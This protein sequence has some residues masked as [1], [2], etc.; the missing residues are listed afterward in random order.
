[1][2]LHIKTFISFLF[3]SV[4]QSKPLIFTVITDNLPWVPRIR[5]N[6]EILQSPLIHDNLT[7]AP[8][9]SMIFYGGWPRPGCDI[10][11]CDA[12]P[13]IDNTVHY[14]IWL[15]VN[16]GVSWDRLPNETLD[17]EYLWQYCTNKDTA[18]TRLRNWIPR[19]NIAIKS[20]SL[21]DRWRAWNALILRA[22]DEWDSIECTEDLYYQLRSSVDWPSVGASIMDSSPNFVFTPISSYLKCHTNETL[23]TI[24][25]PKDVLI[26]FQVQQFCSS[27]RL[28]GL[29]IWKAPN[30]VPR[31]GAVT[32]IHYNNIHLGGA[33]IMYV[34]GGSI[35]QIDGGNYYTKDLWASCDNGYTWTQILNSYPWSVFESDIS[36]EIS[37]GI[38][39]KG[40]MA[41]IFASLIRDIYPTLLISIDGGYTWDSCMRIEYEF[42]PQFGAILSFDNQGYMYIMDGQHSYRANKIWKSGISFDN[43]EELNRSCPRLDKGDIE[44]GL[45]S[46]KT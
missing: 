33:N 4:V 38:S 9:N 17:R 41:V 19:K 26:P 15:S 23:L 32:G 37:L 36:T 30:T 18:Y 35:P 13:D 11:I 2:R 1:M 46:C 31:Y 29:P 22:F 16:D 34:M 27:N 25:D 10:N 3:I 8:I 21:D 43:S 20:S 12:E 39:P 44:P 45:Q 6:L 42:Q 40:V 28:D 24:S 14:D 7:I 5:A